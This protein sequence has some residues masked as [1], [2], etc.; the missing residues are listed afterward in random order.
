MGVDFW[1]WRS[2]T[3]GSPLIGRSCILDRFRGNYL[4]VGNHDDLHEGSGYEREAQY[5]S[6]FHLD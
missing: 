2:Q 3:T 5:A 1:G 6:G 4:N